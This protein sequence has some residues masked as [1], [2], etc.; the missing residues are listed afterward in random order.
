MGLICWSRWLTIPKPKRLSSQLDCRHV[1]YFLS[2]LPSIFAACRPISY[3][4]GREIYRQSL[5]KPWKIS[6]LMALMHWIERPRP[7]IFSILKGHPNKKLEEV[8]TGSN[9]SKL[10]TGAMS[11]R[12][13]PVLENLNQDQP[14]FKGG[15]TVP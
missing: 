5:G 13:P 7:Q 10:H 6:L 11:R 2:G 12:E 4:E 15:T 9:N 1:F 14:A 3:N 8:T